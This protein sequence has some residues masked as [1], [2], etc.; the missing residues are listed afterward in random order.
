MKKNYETPVAEK[1][2][3]DYTQ[4]VVASNVHHGD[5]GHGVSV[6]DQGCDHKPGHEFAQMGPNHHHCG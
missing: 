3:F 1:L 4:T 6:T 2:E 5:K